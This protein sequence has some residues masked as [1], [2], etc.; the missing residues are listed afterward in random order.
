VYIDNSKFLITY[1]IALMEKL[2]KLKDWTPTNMTDVKIVNSIM[3]VYRSRD[4][5]YI[6]QK[7][8]YFNIKI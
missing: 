3:I 4:F 7:Y 5:I 1:F 8:L 2:L 6:D